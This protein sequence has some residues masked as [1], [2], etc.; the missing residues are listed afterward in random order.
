MTVP[1][2]VVD[3]FDNHRKLLNSYEIVLNGL[4][5]E[6]Q[7]CEFSELAREMAIDDRLVSQERAPA[8]AFQVRNSAR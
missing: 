7:D 8:L 1:A 5:Y 2:K 6:P 3:V 4:N